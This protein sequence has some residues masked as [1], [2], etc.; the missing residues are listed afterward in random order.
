MEKI[1]LLL[2]RV[3]VMAG[4]LLALW[5]PL[6]AFVHYME[7][8]VGKDLAAAMWITRAESVRLMRYHGTNGLKV[9]HDRVYIWR[10]SRWIPV[11]K[12]K[13]A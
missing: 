9:T 13:P 7:I 3:L 4:F 12:R 5:L 1:A 11:M 10:D 2:K 6:M 8:T